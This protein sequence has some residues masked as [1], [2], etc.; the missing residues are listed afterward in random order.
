MEYKRIRKRFFSSVRECEW[1]NELGQQGYRL[2][3]KKD[4]RYEFEVQK[5]SRWY[6]RVEWL[7]CS[8][9]SEE[10]LDY[11]RSCEDEG[12]SLAATFSLWAYFVSEEPIPESLQ[13][14]E[15][16]A[17][18][19]RNP[20]LLLFAADAVVAVLI[21]YHIAIR[22]FLEKQNVLLQVPTWTASG[23]PVVNL[24]RRLVYG[25]EV[26]LYRY[27]KF[28][29]RFFGDTKAAMVLGI[30]I[31]LAVILSVTGAFWFTEWM[32]NRPAKMEKQD[33]QQ[34]K[35]IGE[36]AETS[37]EESEVSGEAENHC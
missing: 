35:R 27:S 11:I 12:L 22:E 15:R 36:G 28:C 4:N 20:A 14:R 13:G 34:A 5:E 26:L 16:T 18:H 30:L 8:P 10:A 3:S 2:S 17:V 29:S 9:E 21:G 1:L 25:G 6:Y 7:D 23:N 24:C 37:H 31:P 32:R 19:Y 33:M